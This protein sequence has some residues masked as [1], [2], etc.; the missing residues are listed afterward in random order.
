MTSAGRHSA[1]FNELPSE[2]GELVHIIRDLGVYDVVAA[3]H[4]WMTMS[5]R[6]STDL[7]RLGIFR[8]AKQQATHELQVSGRMDLPPALLA[9]LGISPIFLALRCVFY[10]SVHAKSPGNLDSGATPQTS[11]ESRALVHA[12]YSRCRSVL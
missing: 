11:R 2:V 6:S 4:R 7:Q 10:P 5:W 1:L 8:S 12:T 3:D 9:P